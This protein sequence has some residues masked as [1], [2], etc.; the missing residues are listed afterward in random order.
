MNK[1]LIPGLKSC[2]LLDEF[3]ALVKAGN[4]K[5]A[6]VKNKMDPE[7]L[8]TLAIGIL[9]DASAGFNRGTFSFDDEEVKDSLHFA[10]RFFDTYRKSTR[11]E[12]LEEYLLLMSASAYKLSGR[13]IAPMVLSRKIKVNTLNLDGDGLEDLLLWILKDEMTK[14]YVGSMAGTY[15]KLIEQISLYP[16]HFI[17]FSRSKRPV[18]EMA[19]ELRELVYKIGTPRQLLFGDIISALTK[20]YFTPRE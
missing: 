19:S 15:G 9:G 10:G 5:A 16:F 2:S 7:E 6:C 12:S 18:R 17:K 11:D 3:E 8:F 1:I 4:G 20:E 13:L 14:N